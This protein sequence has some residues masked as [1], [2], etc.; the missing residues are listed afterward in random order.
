MKKT[1]LVTAA[2]FVFFTVFLI[3]S[4]AVNTDEY[5]EKQLEESGARELVFEFF[6]HF[7][8]KCV[9]MVGEGRDGLLRQKPCA[10]E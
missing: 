10:A 2:V 6:E 9:Q 4:F 3:P 5:Y 1:A 8:M 7:L